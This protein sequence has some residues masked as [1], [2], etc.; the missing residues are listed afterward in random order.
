MKLFIT[1]TRAFANYTADKLELDR[2]QWFVCG[3]GDALAGRMFDDYVDITD[4]NYTEQEFLW[5]RTVLATKIRKKTNVS[6]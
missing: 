6:N 5:L 4:H 3:I 1:R 2:S